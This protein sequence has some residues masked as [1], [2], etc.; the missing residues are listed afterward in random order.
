MISS[1]KAEISHYL[2]IDFGRA[3]IGLAIADSETRIAFSYGVLK[4]NRD[5]YRK[6]GEIVE[7]ERVGK[8]VIGGEK[9]AQK[10]LGNPVSN[11]AENIEN[12]VKIAVVFQS[13]IYSTKMAERGLRE[14]GAKRIKRFDDEE[15]ARIILQSWLD[16]HFRK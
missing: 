11:F 15:S 16:F 9:K 10:T 13:E 1:K 7:K 14:K 6:I 12:Q 2:G 8:I 3:K 5:I 4:N